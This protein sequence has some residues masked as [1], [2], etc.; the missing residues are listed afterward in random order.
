MDDFQT[1]FYTAMEL[2]H[3]GMIF[4]THTPVPAGNEVFP[5]SLIDTYFSAY[6]QKLGISREEFLQ[7][8][9]VNSNDPELFSMTVLALRMSSYRNGVSA[10]HGKVA[11]SM[12][13]PLWPD[14]LEE[15]IPIHHI[16]NGI[17]TST[18]VAGKLAELFDTYLGPMWRK[19]THNKEMWKS[20]GDIPSDR[21]WKVH[22]FYKSELVDFARTYLQNRKGTILSNRQKAYINRFLNPQALTIGFA[23]RFATYK[24]A[25]L[26]FRDMGRLKKMLT[27]PDLPVQIILAGKAHPHDNAGKE[28]IQSIIHAIKEHGLEDHIIFLEDYSMAI[29]SAMVKGCDIWLN[30]PR[31]PHEASGTSGMKAAMNGCLHCSIM[32]GWW[33]ESYNG[34]N[35]FSIGSTEQYASTEDQDRAESLS[36]Y[37]ILEQEIIPTF[38]N[39]NKQGIPEQWVEK[40]KSSIMT[41]APE[42][43]TARMVRDYTRKFYLP[44]LQRYDVLQKNNLQGAKELRNWKKH[45]YNNWEIVSFGTISIQGISHAEIGKHIT[46]YAE[47]YTGNLSEKD[48]LVEA[49]YGKINAQGD[50][51]HVSKQRLTFQGYT[52]GKAWFEGQFLSEFGGQQGCTVRVLPTHTLLTDNADIGLCTW[53]K[54][55]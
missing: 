31:R 54:Q 9:Q 47:V 35:G 30:T 14:F 25:N 37:E 20:I 26:L 4:T 5:V 13:Q 46:V 24:R 42:F 49:V 18:W 1:D 36:L 41:I 17:H 6:W 45:I 55:Q 23:R 16:T 52:D 2:A 11:R 34:D 43:S 12:W 32:D 44:A 3:A 19:E 40:M 22:E 39:R 27:N 50:L 48:L 28:I 33:D 38:Y 29:A 51:Q 7:L 53:A 15:E 21:L 10:L 8:G